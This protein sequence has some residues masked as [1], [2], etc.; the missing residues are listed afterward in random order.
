M[1][2][3]SHNAAPLKP[4]QPRE[5]SRQSTENGLK[6]TI[7]VPNHLPVK[8]LKVRTLSELIELVMIYNLEL[9]RQFVNSLKCFKKLKFNNLTKLNLLTI[10]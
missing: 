6:V 1:S 8:D 9:Y 7:S 4:K 3:G 10:Y 2:S 5:K